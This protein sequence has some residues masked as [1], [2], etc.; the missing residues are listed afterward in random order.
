MIYQITGLSP[1]FAW[2]LFL[3]ALFSGGAFVFVEVV[4]LNVMDDGYGDEVAHTH[5]PP[6]E[7]ADFR[8][9]DIVLDELLNDVDVVFPGLQTRQSLIDIRATAF[10]NEGLLDI[11]ITPSVTKRVSTYAIFAEN[12]I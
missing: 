2:L 11:S 7:E 8:A 3:L 6:Q 12:M 10:H 9:A 4:L 5:L 1:R